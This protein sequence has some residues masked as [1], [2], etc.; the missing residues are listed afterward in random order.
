MTDKDLYEAIRNGKAD[1]V[2]TVGTDHTE[3]YKLDYT[4]KTFVKQTV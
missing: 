4:D 2:F 1:V 3:S